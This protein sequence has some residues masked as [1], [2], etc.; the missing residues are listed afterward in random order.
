M[1]LFYG[2][3]SY[4]FDDKLSL[5]ASMRIDQSNLFGTDPK[6]QYRPLWSVGAQY[7]LLGPEQVSWIDRLAFRAT[8]GINGNVAKMS[9]P[10]LTVSDGGVNGWINDYSSYV[11][12]PPNSGL[13]WEKTAVVNIGVDFDLLQ[14]R[15]GGSIEFYNKNTTDLLYNKTGDPT[16]GW[17][18]LMVNYGDMYN[19]G[20]E[21]H[22]NTVN[23]AVK[24]FVWKSMLN[25]SYNKNKLTRIE[26][27]RNDAIYYVNG[28]QI[29]EAGR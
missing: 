13:R 12:Y 17:N 3:A 19:R 27:T 18:S 9:G 23:I 21:I 10:F 29:R 2:N 24:D 6:Y 4:T 20:V 8:Y 26:N 25:F 15:L 22:L 11:T 1:S 7:R 16:Y 14:S 28:G 5:T